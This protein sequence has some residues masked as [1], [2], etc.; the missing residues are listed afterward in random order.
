MLTNNLQRSVRRVLIANRGEIALRIIRACRE[1]G[2]ETIQAY[3][4]ADRDSLPVRLADKTV[5]IGPAPSKDSY[6]DSEQLVGTA[7]AFGAEAIHPGYGFLSERADFAELC[8]E[9]GIIFVGPSA[10]AIRA[11][12]DKA[13]A[14]KIAARAKVPTTPGSK[15]I[16]SGIEEARAIA[17]AIGYP[18]ILKASAGGGGRG[19]RIV[20]SSEKIEEAFVQA[21]REA[22]SAFGDASIYLEKYLTR[23]RHIEIQVLGNGVDVLH[24]GERDCSVQ[25]RNQKLIEEAPS[26]ALNAGQRAQIGEAALRLCR[27]VSY[28]NA[29]TVEFILDDVSGEFYFMEMNTRIQVEHPVTEMTTGIDLVKAQLTIAMTN[30]L[31]CAQDDIRIA[32]HAIEFRINAEDVEDGF[33]PCPGR[34][35]E[36]RLPGG[37]GVR[38]DTHLFAGYVVPPN[39]DSLLGKLI[40]WGRDRGEAMARAERALGELTIN[41]VKTTVPFHQRVLG[42]EVFRRGEVNTRFVPDVLGI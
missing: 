5:C 42:H 18:V 24:L 16:V 7:V 27:E 3:S 32:G 9:A 8:E 33:M 34:I 13:A 4:E 36:L 22:G 20:S 14:R 38:L 23:S 31:P 1:L 26:P 2:L 39:Y 37:P 29:G 41:G 10:N 15:G 30:E 28:R 17:D 40:V 6:L 21:A 19:M 35:A 11:I 12:G 25:R